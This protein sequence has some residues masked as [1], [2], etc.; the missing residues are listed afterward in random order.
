MEA[1]EILFKKYM[2]NYV[3]TYEGIPTLIFYLNQALRFAFKDGGILF[4]T[5][6]IYI[7]N[8]YVNV[9]VPRKNLYQQI[10]FFDYEFESKAM[11]FI[12]EM[13][14]LIKILK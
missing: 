4:D 6:Q 3:L 1:W 14:Q 2:H 5:Y 9:F 7:K 13:I 12:R 8:V 11:P 10:S